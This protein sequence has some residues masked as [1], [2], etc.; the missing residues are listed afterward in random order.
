MSEENK[1]QDTEQEVTPNSK[2]A[3]ATYTAQDM[4]TAIAESKKY[5]QRAQATEA[6]LAK[7]EK[8]NEIQKLKDLETQEKYQDLAN[9]Y[10]SK[11]EKAQAF[12]AKYND[13]K[14]TVRA[15][16][17]NKLPENIRENYMSADIPINILKNIVNDLNVN[18]PAPVN[19]KNAGRFGG[20]DNPD[21]LALNNPEGYKEYKK[22]NSI[23]NV[24]TPSD[25]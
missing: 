22:K 5:R 4:A 3:D 21:D 11:Y 19:N 15:D 2:S 7:L 20:Y 1:A 10:K 9:E 16:Y 12:E 17:L 13:I 6:K 25:K 18:K 8:N 14:S 24:F 23:F